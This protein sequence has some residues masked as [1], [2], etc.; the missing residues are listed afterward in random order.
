MGFEALTASPIKALAESRDEA[1][2][3]ELHDAFVGYYAGYVGEDGSVSAP[4]EYM[5]VIGQRTG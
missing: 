4:R 5:V 3:R 1:A 2:R